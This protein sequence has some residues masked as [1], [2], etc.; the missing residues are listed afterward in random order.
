MIVKPLHAVFGAVLVAACGGSPAKPDAPTGTEDGGATDGA[1]SDVP[2]HT[3]GM[4]GLGAHGLSYY[5]LDHRPLQAT[6]STPPMT[7]QPGS[8]IIV[9]VGRGDLS[10]LSIPTD[11]Q[12]N[13]PYQQLGTSHT[14]QRWP[15]AGTALY[16]FSAA[17]G[18]A[19][20]RVTTNAGTAVT[21]DIAGK[22]DEVT[23]AAVEIREG[24]RIQDFKWI[25]TGDVPNT[26]RSVTTTGP[27]TLIAFWWGD[28]FFQDTQRAMALDGFSRV[29]DNSEATGSFVQSAVAYKNVSDAGTYTVSWNP[30]P[31]QG[32]QLWLVAVQ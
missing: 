29:D 4:P 13:T 15:D 32:A 9:S 24:T 5:K 16:A 10:L 2:G 12:G 1:P 31:S 30:S 18:G 6:L 26:S 19:G 11:N 21:G 25:E 20:F 17:Q 8:M 3:P 7:T 14:Y 22:A 27:A 23:M 28:G